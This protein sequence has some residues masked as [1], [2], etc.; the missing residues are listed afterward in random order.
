MTRLTNFFGRLKAEKPDAAVIS[1]IK[2]WT[3][4]ILALPDGTAFAVN[5]I[6]CRD[7]A[8]PGMETV[9]LVMEPGRKTRAYKIAKN[10]ADVSR[11]DISNAAQTSV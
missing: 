6:V 7:P 9:I 10:L 1:Q 8:C 5:E 3:K 11:E 4:E 2:A